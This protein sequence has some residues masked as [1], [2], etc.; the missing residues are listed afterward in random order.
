MRIG[1]LE[2]VTRELLGEMF[3]TP[4]ELRH[5]AE[6]A[7][8][9]PFVP[10]EVLSRDDRG[11]RVVLRYPRRERILVSAER[12]RHWY[13]YRITAIEEALRDADTTA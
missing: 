2:R 13:P 1:A 7:L 3:S 6:R 8:G 12:D 4:K 10:V 9:E 11:L 5:M